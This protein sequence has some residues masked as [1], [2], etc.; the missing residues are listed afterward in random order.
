[1]DTK[2]YLDE[3]PAWNEAPILNTDTDAERVIDARVQR[4][5]LTDRAYRNAANAEE[6]AEREDQIV[7]AVEAA[8]HAGRL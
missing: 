7:A 8:Y 4:A 6:Q 3:G 1:M 2:H 5:L